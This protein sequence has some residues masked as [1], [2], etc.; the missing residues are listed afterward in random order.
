MSLNFLQDTILVIFVAIITGI[1]SLVNLI[2]TPPLIFLKGGAIEYLFDIE[3]E[4]FRPTCTISCWK[5]VTCHL[6]TTKYT[7]GARKFPH[8]VK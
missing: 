1:N 5:I 8:D 6:P 2:P 3:E 4:F 7:S